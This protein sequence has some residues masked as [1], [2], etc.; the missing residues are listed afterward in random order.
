MPYYTSNGLKLH[1]EEHGHGT[2]LIL[3]HGFAQDSTAWVDPLPVYA[4]H[5]R[6]LALDL[7]GCGR[8]AIP[9]PG[10][11]PK[12]LAGD[13]LAL[14]DQLG[15]AK[16]HFS[17]FSL[18]GAVGQELGIAQSGRFHSLSL[19]STWEGGPCPHMR[20]WIDVRT[21]AIATNDPVLNY[22]TRVVSFFSPEFVN[23][24]EDRV[25][26]FIA[27]SLSNPHPL[28]PMGAQGHAR[29]VLLHDARGRLHNITAPTLLTMGSM[30]RSTL[31]SQARYLHEQIAGSELIFIDGAGHFTP[32]QCPEEFVSISLG[33]LLKHQP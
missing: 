8:S 13:V 12:D 25:D 18:G 30:D 20:R 5:F 2:P 27:R 3:A 16:A 4:R 23:A 15:L 21:R 10:Y 26:A 6:V 17:G 28:T 14:M 32:F 33:F 1:Y 19:H 29:A 7:R 9:E 31:P 11:S 22:G 24:H